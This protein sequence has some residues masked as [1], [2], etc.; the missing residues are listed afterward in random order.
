MSA[1]LSA[2]G[3]AG[4]DLPHR[5][6]MHSRT[7]QCTR[8]LPPLRRQEWIKWT[9][10]LKCFLLEKKVTGKAVLGGGRSL[11]SCLLPTYRQQG[12]HNPGSSLQPACTVHS[13]GLCLESGAGSIAG[14]HRGWPHLSSGYKEQGLGC[15]EGEGAIFLGS[16]TRGAGTVVSSGLEEPQRTRLQPES[17]LSSR[18]GC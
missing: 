1:G 2:P 9:H 3:Q 17:I 15:G 18:Y 8:Q 16:A 5:I 7:H 10:S 13:L 4:G 12:V 14:S 11:R 6:G